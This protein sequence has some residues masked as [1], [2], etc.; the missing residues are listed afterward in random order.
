MLVGPRVA[1]AA[2]A[3]AAGVLLVDDVQLPWGAERRGL[4]EVGAAKRRGLVQVLL[5]VRDHGV[6]LLSLR[7]GLRV[8]LP[9]GVL[10]GGWP[11]AWH[12][13]GLLPG[14]EGRHLR[15]RAVVDLLRVVAPALLLDQVLLPVAVHGH[16]DGR[17]VD[18]GLPLLLEAPALGPVPAA[19]AVVLE[20]HAVQAAVAERVALVA[21]GE[22]AVGAELAELVVELHVAV[23]RDGLDATPARS[24]LRRCAVGAVPRH[25]VEGDLVESEAAAADAGA[26]AAG[27]VGPRNGRHRCACS[28][29][30]SPHRAARGA[31]L[32]EGRGGGGRLEPGCSKVLPPPPRPSPASVCGGGL[33]WGPCLSP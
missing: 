23:L 24:G 27:R 15:E 16:L 33:R 30:V 13:N 20:L 31:P 29:G 28:E 5:L 2:A 6:R 18:D 3:A 32:T 10:R 19:V 22:A 17:Q 7:V 26:C 14:Q 4:V 1:V 25:V 9:V 8:G 12:V 21:P 11:L